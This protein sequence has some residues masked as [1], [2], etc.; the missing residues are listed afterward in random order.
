MKR[1]QIS[2]IQVT[3]TNFDIQMVSPSQLKRKDVNRKF[4][5][6]MSVFDL[7]KKP[8]PPVY[9]NEKGERNVELVN[10]Y[11]RKTTPQNGLLEFT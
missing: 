6:T 1:N 9:F 5:T 8:D 2:L 11:F 10:N 4:T 7:R 3:S